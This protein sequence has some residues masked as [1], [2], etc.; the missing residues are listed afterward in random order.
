[1]RHGAAELLE[2]HVLAGHRLDDVGAGD[3]HVRGLLHHEHEV[4]D[5]G[6]V[7]GAAGA[8]P[9]DHADLR[10]HAGRAHVALEDVAVAGERRRALLDPRA[11]GVVD[12]DERR[13]R[14]IGEVHHLAD[15][16]RHDLAH[17]P[18]E[19]REVLAS[20]EDLAAVDRAVAGDDAVARRARC[21]PSRSRAQ[22]CTANGSVS[23]NE[24]G[25]S[26]RSSRSRAVSL[27]RSCCFFAESRPPGVSADFFFLRSSSIRSSTERVAPASGTLIGRSSLV[28]AMRGSVAGWD[29]PGAST[30]TR[31]P[32]RQYT[33]WSRSRN[34]RRRGIAAATRS[35]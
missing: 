1:M 14:A 16:L 11:A 31:P 12:R 9:H 21:D 35:R 13:A 20:D 10:D 7:D 6:G 24:P 19:H 34:P 18:A 30:S 25:S 29:G 8:R 5:G 4:G 2:R 27:P 17:G 26:S 23:T 32:A 33:P 15:L 3:E 28:L 22:R